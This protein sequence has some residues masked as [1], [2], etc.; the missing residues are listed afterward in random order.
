MRTKSADIAALKRRFALVDKSVWGIAASAQAASETGIGAALN[1]GLAR[2]GL[3][4]VFARSTAD[5][6]AASGFTLALAI[7]AAGDKPV[8]WVRQ[9][10]ARI[11]AGGLYAPGLVE[12]GLDAR[13]VILVQ[14][15]DVPGVLRAAEEAARCPALGAVLIETWGAHRMLDL[16]ASR[17]LALASD[18]SGVSLLMLRIGASPAPS[19]AMTRW[20]AGPALSRSLEADA[21]GDPAF[22]LTLLRRRGGA[23]GGKW[24]EGRKIVEW[25]R[26]RR[27][28]IDREG[29]ASATVLASP[30]SGGMVSVPAH[31]SPV[32][33]DV[34]RAG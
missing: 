14:V 17:R 21:P 22:A 5:S 2:G 13:R 25:N 31:G 10:F 8:V 27:T 28:F 26:D 34:R 4:E 20:E 3:H 30:L 19:A 15:R 24:L 33:D 16:T 32:E 12:L 23:A 6:G 18:A 29:V 9:D 11:E 7:L 1:G